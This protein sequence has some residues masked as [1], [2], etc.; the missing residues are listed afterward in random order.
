M[1][2]DRTG[3]KSMKTDRNTLDELERLYRLWA[4]EV[5]A[6]REE[7]RLT[8][9]TAKTYLLHPERFLRWCRGEFEPGA[10]NR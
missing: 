4:E 3:G 1:E 7:G 9:N 10:R 6:A 8:E 2:P 5:T